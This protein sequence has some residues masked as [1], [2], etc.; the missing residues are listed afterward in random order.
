MKIK[1]LRRKAWK[2]KNR[3]E[4][5]GTLMFLKVKSKNFHAT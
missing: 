5:V 1:N 4:K 2:L 3:C